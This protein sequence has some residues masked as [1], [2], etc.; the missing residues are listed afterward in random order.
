MAVHDFSVKEGATVEKSFYWYSG[1]PVSVAIS[2]I[3]LAAPPVFT[4]AGHGLPT[5]MIPVQLQSI[6]GPRQL[7]TASGE[8]VH[9]LKLS[10]DTFSVPGISSSGLAAY[11][12]GGYLTYVPPKDLT[13]YTAV[14]H[15]RRAYGTVTAIDELTS[16]AGDITITAAEGLVSVRFEAPYGIQEA[17]YDLQ[18]ILASDANHTTPLAGGT[19]TFERN[20]I[21]V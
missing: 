12:G 21:H 10:T 13:G 6:R 19:I 8:R 15:I 20:A 17:V 5:E 18:L 3:T 4:A 16:V 2:A 14:M 11:T 1:T 7:N 9:A